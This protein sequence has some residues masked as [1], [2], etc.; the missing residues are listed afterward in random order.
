MSITELPPRL[1]TPGGRVADLSH[2]E[3]EVLSLM[4]IG[5]S[6]AGIASDLLVSEGAVDMDEERGPDG[7]APGPGWW[8]RPN[9]RSDHASRC[10][11]VLAAPTAMVDIA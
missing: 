11:F 9:D 1:A 7:N 4:A 2:R 8:Q 3:R 6:N 10:R 5:R